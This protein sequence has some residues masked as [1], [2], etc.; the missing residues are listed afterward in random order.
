MNNAIVKSILRIV[1]FVLLQ[2]LVVNRLDLF[3]G[4]ALPFI[5]IFALL[6]LPFQ[7]PRLLVLLICFVVG[8]CM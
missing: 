3:Q 1:F 7:T 5:Y 2:A 6:M 4:L 8:I